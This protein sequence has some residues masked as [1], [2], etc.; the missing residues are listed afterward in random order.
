MKR[1]ETESSLV[2]DL[3]DFPI[4]N[5]Q[6]DANIWPMCAGGSSLNTTIAMEDK[7]GGSHRGSLR[8]TAARKEA[9]S[10]S[11]YRNRHRA[12]VHRRKQA[13]VLTFQLKSRQKPVKIVLRGKKLLTLL[14]NNKGNVSVA[15]ARF[16]H[17]RLLPTGAFVASRFTLRLQSRSDQQGQKHFTVHGDHDVP[18]HSTWME[19]ERTMLMNERN[20]T[21][22]V[23][24]HQL[25]QKLTEELDSAAAIDAAET[26]SDVSLEHPQS[27]SLL[28]NRQTTNQGINKTSISDEIDDIFGALD[29]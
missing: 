7:D 2:V 20:G 10:T 15:G 21:P 29:D 9:K 26:E 14:S 13:N 3:K 28:H 1:L 23:C 19:G 17:L 18:N 11:S 25:Q 24:V 16:N 6:T 4:A 27:D 5:H 22:S 12:R 8:T